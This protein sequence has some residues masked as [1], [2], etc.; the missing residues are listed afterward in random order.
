M[1]ST[2]GVAFAAVLLTILPEW[3]RFIADWSALPHWLA[4]LLE[5]RMIPYSLLLIFLM[6]TRPQGLFGMQIAKRKK[7]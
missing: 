5:N 2:A 7:A 3:L 6:L 1:G 4:G